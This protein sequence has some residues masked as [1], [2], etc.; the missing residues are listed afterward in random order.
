MKRRRRALIGFI[1]ALLLVVRAVLG[2]AGDIAGMLAS[3]TAQQVKIGGIDEAKLVRICELSR[4]NLKL[5]PLDPNA[6]YMHA[7]TL[8]MLAVVADPSREQAA[9]ALGAPIPKGSSPKLM[10]LDMAFLW[11]VKAARLDLGNAPALRWAA[12]ALWERAWLSDKGAEDYRERALQYMASAVWVRPTSIP[13]LLDFGEM[14]M[15][16]GDEDRL[17]RAKSA[18]LK[19]LLCRDEVRSVA[20]ALLEVPGG[21]FHM[22]DVMPDNARF[23][24]E[25][26]DILFERNRIVEAAEAWRIAAELDGLGVP[27]FFGENLFANPGFEDEFGLWFHDW[28]VEELVGSPVKVTETTSKGGS[29]SLQIRLNP[30]PANYFHVS[31]RVPVEGGRRY[32]L[33][34]W[35]RGDGFAPGNVIG[36]EV[37][38]PQGFEIF[39][40]SFRVRPVD[41]EWMP[42]AL[43][44]TAP[45]DVFWLLVRIRRFENPDIALLNGTIYVDELAL[46]P[47]PDPEP[48]DPEIQAEQVTGEVEP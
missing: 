11:Y 34:G 14:N 8:H 41:R 29:R 48:V 10:L 20:D 46:L 44:F 9:A 26:S 37:V 40:E 35:I 38:H 31:Q 25:F 12:W 16:M 15:A 3:D 1:I 17:A 30:G 22:R 28:R 19:A 13:I 6:A 39:A 47:L 21:F 42:I 27:Q 33:S 45:D 36:I 24:R 23:Y 32:E 43:E 5:N 4:I 18:Y 7:K 2:A